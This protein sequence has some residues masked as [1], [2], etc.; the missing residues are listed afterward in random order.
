MASWTIE[1]V[2]DW[3]IENSFENNVKPFKDQNIDGSAL[4]RM[5]NDNISQ[6]LGT[7]DE[8]GIVKRPTSEV[9]FKFREKLDDWKIM[10]EL[11]QNQLIVGEQ[12][13][14]YSR[15][16]SVSSPSIETKRY[17]TDDDDFSNTDL[18]EAIE[19]RP[20]SKHSKSST[21]NIN[22]STPD[23]PK[24]KSPSPLPLRKP[25]T[26]VRLGENQQ[27]NDQISTDSNAHVDK[28]KYLVNDDIH[29]QFFKKPKFVPYLIACVQQEAPGIEIKIQQSTSSCTLDLS[30]S[31]QDVE[32]AYDHIKKL[33]TNVK[34]KTYKSTRA[35][36]WL[37]NPAAIGIIQAIMD[38]ENNIFTICQS[39]ENHYGILEIFYFHD[40]NSNIVHSI[41][42]IILKHI[43]KKVITLAST[44][45]KDIVQKSRKDSEQN[46]SPTNSITPAQ[47]YENKLKEIIEQYNQ[48]HQ[49]I[50]ITLNENI[51]SKSRKQKSI[52]IF[53]YDKLVREF[54]ENIRNL[55][56]KDTSQTFK[57]NTITP[58]QAQYL[59]G[60]GSKELKAIEDEYRKKNDNI[61]IYH[62]TFYAPQH[63]KN[64]IELRINALLSSL[65]SVTFDCM[66]LYYDIANAEMIYLTNI[67]RRN[68]CG[69]DLQLKKTVKS[70]QISKATETS[71]TNY[72]VSRSLM[73][74]S[75]VF[76][77]SPFVALQ[78]KS[79][80]GSI[81]VLIGDIAVQKV[82]IIIIPSM[83]Y[84]LKQSIV[85]R[86]GPIQK[87]EPE[88]NE[89]DTSPIPYFVE[90]TGGNLLCK[91]ILF[92]N[93]P[94]AQATPSEDVF[95]QGVKSFVSKSIEYVMMKNEKSI[96]NLQSIA[97]AVPGFNKKES[98]L[99][100]DMIYTAKQQ[101]ELAK[102]PLKISFVLLPDQQ[103]LHEIL[104]SAIQTMESNDDG[105]ATFSCPLSIITVNLMS[106]M[107][108]NL[109]KCKE[110]MINYIK[111]SIIKIKLDAFNDWNQYLINA[112]YKFCYDRRVLPKIGDDQK[113]RLIGPINNVHE[114]KE[115]YRLNNALIQEKQQIAQLYTDKRR[116]K[117][118]IE[119]PSNI[120]SSICYNV[121]ISYCQQDSLISHR[122][123]DHLID[124]GFC[125]WIGLLG[126]D[127]AFS[128]VN[129]SECVLLCISQ[130]Y[131]DNTF[132]QNTIEYV[133]QTGKQIIYVKTQYC[134]LNDCL[135]SSILND[136]YFQL[137]GS[138][139]YFDLQY[140]K[141][142]LKILQYTKPGY[143]SRL[144]KSFND[145]IVT[146]QN[147]NAK[148]HRN[149]SLLSVLL[150]SEQ[151][152]VNYQ[153][154][155]MKLMSI[156]KDQIHDN[157]RKILID[158]I[159]EIIRAREN[160]CK[161]YLK[162]GRQKHNNNNDD[163]HEETEAF[164][165]D[166]S[167]QQ[168]GIPTILFD[169]GI[170]A[171]QNMLRK[172]R[173]AETKQNIAPFTLSG[174]IND[175]TFPILDEIL[176]NPKLLVGSRQRGL[177][178]IK[179]RSDA[180]EKESRDRYHT[181]ESKKYQ[182]FP[183]LQRIKKLTNSEKISDETNNVDFPGMR[184]KTRINHVPVKIDFRKK[185]TYS[186][187]EII[188]FRQVF[189]QRM[190]D[191]EQELMK[192]CEN[193]INRSG[194][195][196]QQCRYGHMAAIFSLSNVPIANE[197]IEKVPRE[198]MNY[199]IPLKFPWNGVY[200]SRA[201]LITRKCPSTLFSFEIPQP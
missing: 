196:S 57:L 25:S 15:R 28:T 104:L 120:S 151:R 168:I 60:V 51:I 108:K 115:K 92:A 90:T 178:Y 126:S 197:E 102:S 105:Y 45:D 30:G 41:D 2:G 44:V 22:N 36:T 131:F 200:E 182:S 20:K 54:I 11:E 6:I 69:C 127:E 82:D 46:S 10:A 8:N 149:Y 183:K 153:T 32:S 4:M 87:V 103:T 129:K 72:A 165:D 195:L 71:L 93:W 190:K 61:R 64:D 150:T 114:A 67:A 16:T 184:S 143:V 201:T 49:T 77:S 29:I 39:K 74:E 157:D 189:V 95:L 43:F 19:E 164:L 75:E 191:N 56:E 132:S 186:K 106:S 100:K 55:M 68:H 139:N 123:A 160:H 17:W 146:Q 125:I 174:D 89:G 176:Q 169:S 112:F 33:F 34:V 66:P 63:L 84:G 152:Q 99:A 53:G 42:N 86:A 52:H 5:D 109:E 83:P 7:S 175:A 141:L 48:E 3:L 27:T 62:D 31:N 116:S 162:A 38:N 37:Q 101:I 76:S 137:F 159:E 70:Y 177:V 79:S 21:T 73:K 144:Q 9:K 138:K 172:I 187:S 14:K 170:Y 147:D 121:M 161:K 81:K 35:R 156:K 179:S 124:E 24:D 181:S 136:T 128:Q 171:Y 133:K 198:H 154:Y 85:E 98:I 148:Y 167:E 166:E 88:V 94:S 40:E 140:D 96:L 188:K 130:D 194:K 1:Q 145:S 58:I 199:E 135:Q 113:L 185:G 50:S 134:M 118:I 12:L 110:K 59:S 18:I 97:F 192:T 142:L 119:N 107:H 180:E 173:N 163:E 47:Q 26:P 78:S 13:D 80:N 155:V 65:K 122:L 23:L 111:G 91:I 158:E 193:D 117:T